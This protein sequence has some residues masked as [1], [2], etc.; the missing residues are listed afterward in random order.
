MPASSDTLD[1][2]QAKAEGI[3]YEA[4]EWCIRSLD[5]LGGIRA[6]ETWLSGEEKDGSTVYT[7]S[8][9]VKRAFLKSGEISLRWEACPEG[10]KAP[11]VYLEGDFG[12]KSAAG[13]REKDSHQWE[14]EGDFYLTDIQG[15]YRICVRP[16][17]PSA[18]PMWKWKACMRTAWQ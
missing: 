2:D 6:G 1:P 15:M 18:E 4:G 13:F 3:W 11:F 17:F 5:P 10:E 14:T 16:A 12:V 9:S 7:I 8:D